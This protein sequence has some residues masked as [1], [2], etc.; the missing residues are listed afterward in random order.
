MVIQPFDEHMADEWDRFVVQ[1]PAGTIL[2]TRRFMSYHGDRFEDRSLMVRDE[3]E[4]IIAVFPAAFLPSDKTV[5]V[6][7]PG[8]TY[9]GMIGGDRCRGESMVQIMQAVCEYYKKS[10]LM[11]LQY[12][13]VPFIYHTMPTQDDLYALFRLN[14]VRYRCD[15]SATIDLAHRGR[16]GSR[17]KRGYKKAVKSGALIDVG[18]QYASGLWDVL[19]ANLKSK[20]DAKPVH[21]LDEILLLHERFPKEIQFV[22]ALHEGKVEAGVVLFQS[23]MVSHAQ[24]IASSDVGYAVNALDMVFE[25]CI[26]EAKEQGKRY[27]DFG[28]S[29]EEAG[30]VLNQG[31]YGFKSEFGSGGVVHEFYEVDLEAMNVN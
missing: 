5:V 19:Y 31:L 17:R 20:Y 27:F 18:S 28:I 4:K 9:G 11:K 8:V 13:A 15:L 1:S 10:G 26:T 14:A 23:A 6:S 21:T 25:H 7:H 24:Y 22:A 16:V 3:K 29:N 2:H 12:K 30:R